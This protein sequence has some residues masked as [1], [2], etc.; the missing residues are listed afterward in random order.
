[1]KLLESIEWS[2]PV[3]LNTRNG[4]RLLRKAPITKEF[5][6]EWGRDKELYKSILRTAGISVGKYRDLWELT[7]WSGADLK[8]SSIV[9]DNKVEEQEPQLELA[10]LKYPDTLFQFQQTS[11]QLG[12][13]S[14]LKYNRVL[15]GHS[16]GVGK[17]FCALGIARELGKR[18]AVICPLAV[19]TPWYR[20]AKLM[21]VGVYEVSGWEYTKTGKSK[22]GKWTSEDKKE[23]KFELPDDVI[24]I[25]D[26]AH[27]G[28]A[29]G[30]SQ[31]SF[32]VRDS[33]I[34][35]V[36][37]IALSATIADAPD[38]LWAMGL[39]LGLHR[40]GKDY[41]RFLSENGCRKTQFGFKYMGGDAILRRLHKK[42]YPERGN[43]LRHSDLGEAFPETLVKAMAFDMEN[44]KAI[45]SEYDDLCMRVEEL[46]N[47]ENFSA[48]VLAEQMRAR[49][50]I[51]L[52]K[53]PSV[54]SLAKDY[55]EE[56]NSVFIVV[57]F[58]ETL[59]FLR[60]ELKTD[61]IICGGQSPMERQGAIDAFQNDK[62]RVIVGISSACREGISLHD[63]K[64][65]HPRVALIFPQ[66]SAYDLRQCLGRVHR[67]GGT[68]S[69]QYVIYAAGVK[70]EEDTCNSLDKKLKN[71]DLIAD[72][73]CDPSISLS[74]A[75]KHLQ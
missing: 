13:A 41:Y 4:P 62:A 61:A 5:W 68:R 71:M 54:V 2:H 72:G 66:P 53:A 69:T 16:T 48:N 42:I 64:G 33:V 1:M 7:W 8:F 37:S 3:T 58:R 20:A 73:E 19:V 57:S 27:R 75:Q 31:N 38:K 35:N 30:T 21:N 11:V 47:A 10:P 28:K 9:I 50:K 12:V 56:G 52:L 25:F 51:E 32:L 70:I 44:A 60:K 55:I 49:Q 63:T 6:E 40:G 34:Q 74:V 22:I 46:R 14:I 39:F 45:A 67:S 26:E 23:F 18:V 65:N 36:Q 17:T 15:L 24:L 43:R 59:E 29:P